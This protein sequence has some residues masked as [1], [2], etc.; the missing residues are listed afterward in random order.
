MT[1]LA[2][3]AECRKPLGKHAQLGLIPNQETCVDCTTKRRIRWM[4][5]VLPERGASGWGALSDF[6]QE[7]LPSVREQFARRGTLSEK[8]YQI[9]ERIYDKA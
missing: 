9:L 4:L 1:D 2:V 3:C 7:F 6:E 8:Q 5:E